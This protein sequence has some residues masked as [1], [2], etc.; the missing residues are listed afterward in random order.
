MPIG[1]ML[2]T[3]TAIH[4]VDLAAG[5][6]LFEQRIPEV[7][8]AVELGDD[9]TILAV[10]MWKEDELIGAFGFTVRTFAR[11]PT[12]RSRWSRTL[13]LKQSLLSRTRGYSTNCAREPNRWKRS[14][15][16]CSN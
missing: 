15:R 6:D 14:L 3:K 4:V 5:P 9:R 11:L 7:I 12:N 16:S 2:S 10:P 8:A 13:P 1:R